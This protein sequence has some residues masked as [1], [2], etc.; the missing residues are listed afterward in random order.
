M[1]GGVD[2]NPLG[3]WGCREAVLGSWAGSF[4]GSEATL[5]GATLCVHS[6]A[7][8]LQLES[9]LTDPRQLP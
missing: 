7:L 1:T 2:R 9:G 4:Q 3:P 8:S 6:T 5:S